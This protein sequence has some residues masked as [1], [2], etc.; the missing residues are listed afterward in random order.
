[1]PKKR[2]PGE[3]AFYYLPQR[4]L[5]R[6][7]V[8]VGYTLD[9]GRKQLYVHA[10]SQKA[11]REKLKALKTEIEQYGA[12]LDKTTTVAQWADT[13]LEQCRAD[14]DPKSYTTSMA[15][16]RKW[17][18]PII[19]RHKL[20]EL[21]PSH[22]REVRTAL[23][24]SGRTPST[25][26]RY[27]GTLS[28]MLSDAIEEKLLDDNPV[29]GVMKGVTR[30]KQSSRGSLTVPEAL[31]V[32]QAAAQY[33]PAKASRFWFK[34]L[35]GQRQSEILGA[36]RAA[37][38][39]S[40]DEEGISSYTVSWKLEE[41]RWQHDCTSPC[42]QRWPRYCP[43]RKLMI[44][45]DFECIHLEGR[46]FLTRPK[47][48]EGRVVPLI[49]AHVA[50]LRRHLALDEGVHNP[51]GLIWHNDDGSPIDAKQDSAEWKQLL[52]DAGVITKEENRPSGTTKTG[53]V[54]R[55]TTVT[56]LSM[57]GVDAHLIGEIVG[58]SSV[59]MT[60]HYRHTN[61]EEKAKAMALLGDV[62]Q[63]KV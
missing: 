30:S 13:W 7:V 52:F 34:L 63:I 48:Q 62:L 2:S 12:P 43:D 35:G 17:I 5:W 15:A 11:C 14:L 39:M 50:L 51:H 37:L 26:T 54:A 46:F 27:L 55:H 25:A 57:M 3:G 28:K 40:A 33:P 49:P 19:G 47:S 6:G 59:H 38:T 23:I 21:R 20:R 61:L 58:H 24:S 32:L 41:L 45:D 4:K 36:T 10:R 29:T 53:H 1:M 42:G 22:I 31:A 16:V 44:P 18:V 60:Q 9:G 8:D 56:L